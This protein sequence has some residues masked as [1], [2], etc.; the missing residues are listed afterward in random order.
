MIVDTSDNI[1]NTI[2]SLAETVLYALLFVVIVVFLFL[3][4]WRATL[5]ICITIPLSL[6]AS[7]IYL[8]VTGNTINIISLSSLSIA[9]GMVV[10]DAIVVL[11]NVT[12]HIERGS[13]PKQ[14][15]VHGTNEVAISVIAST[16]TMIAVFFPLT[17]VSG[18]SGVMFKQLGWMMCAI[19]F[20]S[21]VAALSLT[22]MLCS[23]L[24]RLQKKQSKTFKLLFGPIEKGLDALDTGYAHMLNWAVRHRP[25][26]IFGCIVFFVVS[27]FCA[28]SIGTE[29]FPAQDNARIAVQLEL[30][31]GTRK[32]LA[33]EISE[34]LTNQW[35]NKYKGVMTVCNY[36]VGQADSD[37]TWASMQDNGSHI[38][39]FNIS[40]VDPG[41]RDISLEQVCDEMR[42]DLKKYPEFSK[43]QV[44][45]GGSNTGMSAQAS[46]D[47]EVYGYSMEETD[48]VAAR[49]KRELLNVKG[50]SEVNISRS[51]YQPEYQV[52]FDRE[53]LALHGLN[54]ATAGNYLR[55][56]I[57]G[58]IASKYRE[59]GDEYDIKV[60]YAPEHR[61]SIESIENILI[62]N[63]RGEAVRVKE[64][65]KVVE[66]FAPPT[67]E[68]KDRERI[69]T[70]S[71]GI[72]G[73]ETGE[74]VEE[75][76]GHFSKRR[77]MQ[78]GRIYEEG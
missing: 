46:A 48:S 34:K 67:I 32:E 36:T 68:R 22:P 53:K 17:M 64:L 74:R 45:L 49:L 55:N 5:I 33:Q 72:L 9:I 52:D 14:A 26:V 41:D 38:I 15:A 66:R 57:N 21:T 2:D 19:M 25:I 13:D 63:S 30:P 8:A 10:D 7:F 3:G 60:R 1:L 39:S 23:Q 43:A 12:T 56:R 54:L 50:V 24:L 59:D 62:Y 20:I 37:N 47:F 28:K 16:L 61:T 6:I 73:G 29:F 51:D 42:E 76:E 65:G 71:A 69:V 11:E 27:L 4:R 77:D 40:L 58:A 31:I 18:M 44:I 78:G 35:L 75:G 70:V